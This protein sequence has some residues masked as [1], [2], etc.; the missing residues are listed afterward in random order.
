MAACQISFYARFT[1]T[2]LFMLFSMLQDNNKAVR[3]TKCSNMAKRDIYIFQNSI[4][5]F[6]LI[7]SESTLNNSNVF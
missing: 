1:C 6:S 5:I 7:V 2:M 3:F 4:P